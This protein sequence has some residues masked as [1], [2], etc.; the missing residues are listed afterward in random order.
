[1]KRLET[2]KVEFMEQGLNALPY[3]Q[4]KFGVPVGW[5]LQAQAASSTTLEPVGGKP[6]IQQLMVMTQTEIPLRMKT[7]ISYQYGSQPI[8]ENGEINPIFD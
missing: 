1:M 3:F 2:I 8:T 7:M 6:I 4:M 5:G